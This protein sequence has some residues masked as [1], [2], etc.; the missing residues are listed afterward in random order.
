V[1]EACG[2]VPHVEPAGRELARRV[3]PSALDVELH[4]GRVRSLT[5]PVRDPGR[6]P[7]PGVRWVVGKQVCVISQPGTD[8][9]ELCRDL[10][11]VAHDQRTGDRVNR[12][13]V[14]R[15]GLEPTTGGL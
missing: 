6:V 1:A 8:R 11:Q 2:S 3:M 5:D 12:K 13:P 14:G 7:R 9:R 10:S 4:P 15:V